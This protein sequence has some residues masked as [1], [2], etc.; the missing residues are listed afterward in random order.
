MSATTS[1]PRTSETR[2]AVS[3]DGTRIAYD[4]T[5]PADG[6]GPALVVVEGA[7][8]HR[9]MGAAKTLTPALRER[10][11]VHAYDRRGRGE[12]GPGPN[13]RSSTAAYEPQREVE[14]LRAVLDAAGGNPFVFGASSGAALALE[15]ARQ[16]APMR[17]LAVY[18]A[19]FIID[20]A[21]APND[22]DLGARTQALVD[23]GRPGDA[24]RLFMKVVGAPA[25]MVAIMRLLPVW[26]QLT[27]VAPTLPHDYSIVLPF[28]QGAPLPGGRY[29][30]V[31]PAT[32]VIAGGK[33]PAYLRN[34]QAAIA[35]QLPHGRLVTLPGQTHMIRAKATAPVLLDH[36]LGG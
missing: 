22:P 30:E 8:C 24:V 36:F 17:R 4:V 9:A 1:P 6:S 26:K 18:E 13:D 20:D 25:P 12:S 35:E 27:A 32:L 34:A 23:A 21:H 31:E 15:A 14:D 7:L 19:P 33:S 11:T 5:G 29:A 2:Y 16:G 3:A 10:F 28:Q